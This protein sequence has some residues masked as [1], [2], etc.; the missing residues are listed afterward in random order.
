MIKRWYISS[1]D[2]SL[3]STIDRKTNQSSFVADVVQVLGY[4][5]VYHGSM[6][7]KMHLTPEGHSTDFTLDTISLSIV[8]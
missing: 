5:F 7:L 8:G 2:L 3:I 4:G 1:T 6:I